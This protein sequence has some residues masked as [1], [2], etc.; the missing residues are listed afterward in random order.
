MSASEK[1]MAIE[2]YNDG[3][4]KCVA[5]YDLVCGDG[6][7]AN[8]F[9]IVNG[10][11]SALIDPGGELIYNELFMQSYKYLFSK[12]LEYVIAS[13]QDP[14]VISSLHKW[15]AGSDC[16]VIVPGLWERFIPHFS[17]PGKIKDR[18]IGIPE[19]GM[20]IYLGDAVLKAL[21]A[22]FLHS[23]GNFQ[24]YD[25]ISKI[26]FSG[27]MGGSL[28]SSEEDNPVEDFA[29]HIQ[30]MEW[31]HKRYMGGNK[32]C[33]LWVNMVRQL[34]IEWIVPQHGRSF[35]GKAMVEEFL[36]WIEQLECGIDL[37]T[38][39]TYVVP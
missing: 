26:L 6:I 13:H 4:H 10:N 37:V 16:R 21:P 9:L 14:D 3:R 24:F 11:H 25:P 7:Q 38:Q 29:M 20:N 15:L 18:L 39:E 22:H 23:E 1:I 31:F 5:F 12:K 36:N 17:T 19:E 35:K 28:V 8:Q 33:R 2:L 32:A 34:E 30:H 27:D